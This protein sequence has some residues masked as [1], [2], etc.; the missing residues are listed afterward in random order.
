MKKV[1]IEDVLA[2]IGA[3]GISLIALRVLQ[4]RRKQ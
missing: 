2:V 3:A 4:Q 1:N